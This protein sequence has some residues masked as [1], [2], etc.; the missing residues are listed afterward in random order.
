MDGTSAPRVSRAEVAFARA[1]TEWASTWWRI[2][3]DVPDDT[4][5]HCAGS[6]TEIVAA[7]YLHPLYRIRYLFEAGRRY[8][9]CPTLDA[10]MD[11]ARA[12]V[13]RRA[14]RGSLITG[15]PEWLL[16]QSTL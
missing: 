4:L 7:G 16:G 3:V 6:I 11:T 10:A 1:K 15:R 12:E 2:M 5:P 8:T 13:L 9:D 14:E